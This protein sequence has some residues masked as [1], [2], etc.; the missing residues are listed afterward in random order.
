DKEGTVS[1]KIPKA[2]GLGLETEALDGPAKGVRISRVA[3]R[4]VAERAGLEVGEEITQVDGAALDGPAGLE[5]AL[6]RKKAGQGVT[7]SLRRNPIKV[8]AIRDPARLQ[9]GLNPF[10]FDRPLTD[11]QR[12]YTYEAEF[13]PKLVQNEKGEVIQRGLPGDR[14][15]NNRA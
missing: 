5:L 12:S 8:V 11:E 6:A 2:G 9:F 14:V 13:E 10:S 1:I 4:S 15:Q 7:L 3:E